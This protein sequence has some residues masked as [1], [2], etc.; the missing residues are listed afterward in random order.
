LSGNKLSKA[1]G[2]RQPLISEYLQLVDGP[3]DIMSKVLSHE[4]SF[5]RGLKELRTRKRGR[6][7]GA[8]LPEKATAGADAPVVN[9]V[10]RDRSSAPDLFQIVDEYAAVGV[11]NTDLQIA[12]VAPHGR[13][14][15]PLPPALRTAIA[16]LLKQLTD[17]VG[18][19]NSSGAVAEKKGAVSPLMAE[20]PC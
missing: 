20:P 3:G 12:V 9:T 11:P 5:T 1:L 13:E 14:L 15:R 10:R 19:L 18:R 4:W 7:A 17:A 16:D 6:A 8:S 2:L